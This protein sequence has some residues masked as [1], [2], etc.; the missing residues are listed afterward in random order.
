MLRAG[1]SALGKI[2]EVMFEVCQPLLAIASKKFRLNTA[3]VK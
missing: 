2:G 1:A 3:A